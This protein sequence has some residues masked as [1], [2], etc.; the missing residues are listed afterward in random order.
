MINELAAQAY[1]SNEP[2]YMLNRQVLRDYVKNEDYGYIEAEVWEARKI[3]AE[4]HDYVDAELRFKAEILELDKMSD[5]EQQ[6]VVEEFIV[7]NRKQY[8]EDVAT[9]I[10]TQKM[11]EMVLEFCKEQKKEPP[12]WLKEAKEGLYFSVGDYDETEFRTWADN[13]MMEREELIDE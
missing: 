6:E 7:N 1:W 13:I 4:L 11:V 9:L 2:D 8:L 5:E 12:E 10:R 3:Q